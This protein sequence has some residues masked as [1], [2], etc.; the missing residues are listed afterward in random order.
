MIVCGEDEDISAILLPALWTSTLIPTS[1]RFTLG[2]SSCTGSRSSPNRGLCWGPVVVGGDVG[3]PEVGIGHGPHLA[4]DPSE[5]PVVRLGHRLPLQGRHLDALGHLHHA[6]G[7]VLR[8]LPV[9]PL[10]VGALED[11]VGDRPFAVLVREEPVARRR[12]Q[13]GAARG[14]PAPVLRDAGGRH[15]RRRAELGGVT[16]EGPEVGRHLLSLHHRASAGTFRFVR[17]EP[18]RLLVVLDCFVR[19]VSGL[20]RGDFRE[21]TSAFGSWRDATTVIYM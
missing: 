9:R 6:H 12:L 17:L 8:P 14:G 4:G 11:V 7:R 5:H 10:A 21:V 13:A 19:N 16:Q 1:F 15:D 3:A 20:G 2:I 18:F